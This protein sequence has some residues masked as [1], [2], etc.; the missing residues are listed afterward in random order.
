MDLSPGNQEWGRRQI[1]KLCSRRGW[2]YHLQNCVV[3][4]WLL[5]GAGA[6]ALM[7]WEQCE[8]RSRELLAEPMLGTYS[9]SGCCRTELRYVE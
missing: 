7:M 1:G 3:L 9:P 4:G 8:R 2:S 6:Q 5:R